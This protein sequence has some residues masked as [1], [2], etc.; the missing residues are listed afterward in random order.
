[1]ITLKENEK[2]KPASSISIIK[3]SIVLFFFTCVS[4]GTL[5]A[6]SVDKTIKVKLTD[7]KPIAKIDERFQSYNV[8]MV[9][10]VGG[11]FWIPYDKIDT[12]KPI[13][14]TGL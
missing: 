7:L 1:M 9:E 3:I 2:M 14:G 12:T 5:S 4:L 6:Q 13:T 10:V 8:E 11:N